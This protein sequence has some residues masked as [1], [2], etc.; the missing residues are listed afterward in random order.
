MIFGIWAECGLDMVW[1]WFKGVGHIKK[2]VNYAIFLFRYN[3][4]FN[5]AVKNS[6]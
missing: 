6:N 5:E 4:L 2:N 1:G 3:F